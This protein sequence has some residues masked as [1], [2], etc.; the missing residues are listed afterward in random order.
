MD[1]PSEMDDMIHRGLLATGFVLSGNEAHPLRSS[2]EEQERIILDIDA[3]IGCLKRQLMQL[4]ARRLAFVESSATKRALLAPVRKLAPEILGEV[5]KWCIPVARFINDPCGRIT[6]NSAPLLL[7]QVCRQWRRVALGTP[8][9]WTTL[10]LECD[11]AVNPRIVISMWLQHSRSLPIDIYI[12][13]QC[14]STVLHPI[15]EHMHRVRVF[16]YQ[17]Q[18]GSVGV[19]FPA[20]T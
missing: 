14:N 8:H 9:L 2:I 11:P 16:H 20:G 3:R 10:A 7:I 4:R 12:S 17:V 6:P 13:G 15:S 19:V 1:L 18:A 5:F